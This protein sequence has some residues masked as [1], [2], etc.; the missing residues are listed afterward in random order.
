MSRLRRRCHPFALL[1]ILTLV[2]GAC[3]AAGSPSPAASPSPGGSPLGVADL[4]Y[5]IVDAL[6]HLSFCDPDEYPIRR[7]DEQDLA[8]QHLAEIR[9]DTATF[10]AIAAHLGLD[11]HAAT[12]TADQ[13]AAI[14]GAWKELRALQLDPIGERY[15]FDIRVGPDTAGAVTRIVGTIGR[16]GAI[17]VAQRT[18]GGPPNCPICLARGTLIDTPDGAVPVEDVRPGMP[19][20][21]TD[22]W[23]RR[24]AGVVLRTG[25]AAVPPDHTVIHLV[26]ADGRALTASPGHPLPDGRRLGDLR[27]GDTVDGS[28]VVEAD[29][30]P[31]GRPFTFDLVASGGT[32]FYWADGIL[33]ASTLR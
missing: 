2:A 10:A 17:D 21:T 14:Y 29:P 19:V 12:F 3:A 16:T 28:L 4:K 1:S 30:G 6:G 22:R 32:G 15:R 31:Y 33:L 9:A 11:A 7:S 26:L 18:D 20:W 25:S 27:P 8:R 23:G 13:M 24:M 5:R